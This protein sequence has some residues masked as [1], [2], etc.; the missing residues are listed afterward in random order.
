M[1]ATEPVGLLCGIATPEAFRH[2]LERAG[3][4]IAATHIVPDHQPFG[5]ADL[6][7]LA[8]APRWVTTAKDEV[9]LL[10]VLSAGDAGPE[11]WVWDVEFRFADAGQA[12]D[13]LAAVRDVEKKFPPR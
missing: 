8:A 1:L 11:I 3:L 6:A 9:R 10:D 2:D 4:R 12:A 7:A 5:A 13:L